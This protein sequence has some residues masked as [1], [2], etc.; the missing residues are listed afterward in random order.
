MSAQRSLVAIV[1]TD[2]V[3]FSALASSNEERAFRLLEADFGVMRSLASVHG[4]QVLK[5]MGDGMLMIFSSAAQ[6]LACSLEVQAKFRER[7][8]TDDGPMLRHRIGIHL[9]DVL[10]S[11]ADA[12]GDSV[13]IAARLQDAAPPGG[14]WISGTV[15]EVV[16]SRLPVQ[17]LDRGPMLLKNIASP[18]HVLEVPGPEGPLPIRL[19]QAPQAPQAPQI[20]QIP[21]TRL[22]RPSPR[23]RNSGSTWGL[24][25]LS[26]TALGL[27]GMAGLRTSVRPEVSYSSSVPMP[28]RRAEPPTAHAIAPVQEKKPVVK[29]APAAKDT[30]TESPE[31]IKL[32]PELIE[33]LKGLLEEEKAEKE[34]KTA[35]PAPEVTVTATRNEPPGTGAPASNPET[36]KGDEVPK[37]EPT[38]PKPEPPTP[39]A[40]PPVE[41]SSDENVKRM[42][43]RIQDPLIKKGIVYQSEIKDLGEIF[44]KEYAF[45]D[46]AELMKT[47]PA[48]RNRMDVK[49]WETLAGFRDSVA[50]GLNGVT[51]EAPLKVNAPGLPDAPP[52]QVWGAGEDRVFWREPGG[53]VHELEFDD[54][55]PEQIQAMA[56]ALSRAGIDRSFSKK[57]RVFEREFKLPKV[58][59]NGG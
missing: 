5:T 20:P 48:L 26:I 22:E 49:R 10:L 55:K 27:L 40:K 36:P 45:R 52:V 23:G 32:T 44:K 13:N 43:S 24:G 53:K 16:K 19:P 46:F 35:E 39:P 17:L 28:A 42:I 15:F 41:R 47:N 37:V 2:A 30:P 29:D 33:K 11:E 59:V 1:F 56:H 51:P 7:I 31:E 57:I 50:K 4:G 18:V 38:R 21:Q 12:H 9:G 34:S 58:S 8:P 25:L 6:A 3:A 54:L 14:I